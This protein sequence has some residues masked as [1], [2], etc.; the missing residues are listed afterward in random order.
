LL[1]KTLDEHK[2]LLEDVEAVAAV[3]EEKFIVVTIR[4]RIEGITVSC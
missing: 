4:K 2:E 3:D 1:G